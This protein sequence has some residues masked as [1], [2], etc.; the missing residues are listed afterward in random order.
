M[1]IPQARFDSEAGEAT[2]LRSKRSCAVT[3]PTQVPTLTLSAL[4]TVSFVALSCRFQ[5]AP[6]CSVS[7]AAMV[8]S[9]VRSGQ[10]LK[11]S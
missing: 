6:V 10:P 5:I 2:A 8:P 7:A 1:S 4:L 11:P 3:Y 9:R